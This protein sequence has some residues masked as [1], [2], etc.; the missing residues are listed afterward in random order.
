MRVIDTARRKDGKFLVLLAFDS[1][2]TIRKVMTEGQLADTRAK[3]VDLTPEE[4]LARA[5]PFGQPGYRG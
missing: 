2:R 1:G 5:I 3:E 4:V